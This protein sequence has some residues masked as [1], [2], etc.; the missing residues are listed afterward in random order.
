MAVVGDI[1]AMLPSLALPGVADLPFVTL[2]LG[3]AAIFLVSFGAGM[4]TARSFGAKGGYAVDPNAE[5]TGFGA[6]NMAAGLFGAF[7]VTASD[8]RTAVNLTIGGRSQ[9]D[10]HR[11]RLD[12]DCDSAVP[13]AGITHHARFLRSARFSPRPQSA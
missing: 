11:G 4:I 2:A 3:A 10:E 6:A 7:P 13:R 9:A 8:S 1:P 5:L 12:L